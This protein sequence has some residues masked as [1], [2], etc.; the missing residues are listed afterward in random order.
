MGEE[1]S[2]DSLVGHNQHSASLKIDLALQTLLSETLSREGD[3]REIARFASVSLPGSHAGD[4]LTTVPSPSLGLLLK[5]QEFIAALRYR[6][7]HPVYTRDGPCPACGQPSD[8]LGDHSLNCAWQ[9]ERIAR[10]NWL[11]D[12]LFNA[13]VSASLGPTREGRALLPGE[14]GKPADVFIPHWAGGKD[15]ALDVT[16]VNPLQDALV[17]GAATTPGHALAIAHKRKLDKSWEP[18]HLQGITFIPV[19]V[20]SLGAWHKSAISEVKKLGCAKARQLGEEESVEVQRLF[21]KLSV[22]L[23]RGNCALLNNRAPD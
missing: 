23:M 13:A 3:A 21:Q 9:G 18:C 19:A 11:R 14:G 10:H 8:R 17:Q 16:V 20:E 7:G 2:A 6:L 12:E 4:W 22:A 5:P 15:V 1:A